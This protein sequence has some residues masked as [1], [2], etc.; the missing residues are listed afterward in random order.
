MSGYTLTPRQKSYIR[1][2][3][4]LHELDPSEASGELNIVPFLDI[5]TNIIMFLLAT[6]AAVL[7]TVELEAHLP[8]LSRGRARGAVDTGSTLN[9]SVTVSEDGIIVA[10]S[11]GKLAPGC[12][13]MLSGR[14]ITIPRQ[15]DGT[16]NFPALTQCLVTVHGTFP[17]ERQSI[18]TADPNIE[19]NDIIHAMDAMR[20]DG[21]TELFPEIMLS[22]GVR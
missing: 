14:V 5:V 11:G 18:L 16:F 12:T 20:S 2:K 1:K 19:F 9:L 21:T 7:T 17:D 22:A 4:R 8:T 3:T 13:Q 15:A 6:T 10:G